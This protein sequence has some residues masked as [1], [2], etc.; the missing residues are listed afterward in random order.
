MNYHRSGLAGGMFPVG[1]GMK[2]KKEKKEG[3]GEEGEERVQGWQSPVV[4]AGRGVLGSSK[5][6]MGRL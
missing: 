5:G 2:E 3:G 1:V 6:R 4:D